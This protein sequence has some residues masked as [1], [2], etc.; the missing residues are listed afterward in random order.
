MRGKILMFSA[1]SCVS[2]SNSLQEAEERNL[3]DPS[4]AFVFRPAAAMREVLIL[5]G[6]AC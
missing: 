3:D 2:K 5:S 6:D 1:T 4:V